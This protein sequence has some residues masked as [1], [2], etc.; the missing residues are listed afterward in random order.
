LPVPDEADVGRGDLRDGA[1]RVQEQDI[2]ESFALRDAAT[3]HRPEQSNVLHG[4]DFAAVS[5]GLEAHWLGWAST[6]CPGRDQDVR[7]GVRSDRA[8]VD[9]GVIDRDAC[10]YGLPVIGKGM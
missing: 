8:Q 6:G 7:V 9:R 10:D 4:R 1:V 5:R 3:L 2:I